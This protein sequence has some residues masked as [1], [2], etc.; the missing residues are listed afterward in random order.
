MAKTIIKTSG[1]STTEIYS[2]NSLQSVTNPETTY[3][4]VMEKNLEILEKVL[5]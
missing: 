4:K 3:L 1:I 2:L 5:S